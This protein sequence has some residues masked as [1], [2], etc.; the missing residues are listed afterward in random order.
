MLLN[1]LWNVCG[2]SFNS[3]MIS[4]ILYNT[5]SNVIRAINCSNWAILNSV[6]ILYHR[7]IPHGG[8]IGSLCVCVC[9]CVS[10]FTLDLHKHHFACCNGMC[11][12][13]KPSIWK[14]HWMPGKGAF[15]KI[16]LKRTNVCYTSLY[17]RSRI[18]R[19]YAE[20]SRE[21]KS[22]HWNQATQ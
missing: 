11:S 4:K 9:V 20:R 10:A 15:C 5:N 16:L 6:E 13:H 12:L 8:E 18:G 17:Q 21:I 14:C 22:E 3:V 7:S 19:V 1:I 2:G